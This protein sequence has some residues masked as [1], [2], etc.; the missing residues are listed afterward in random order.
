MSE[1]KQD[2][3]SRGCY[4][5][6]GADRLGVPEAINRAYERSGEERRRGETEKDQKGKIREPLTVVRDRSVWRAGR[7]LGS[8]VIGPRSIKCY[9][10]RISWASLAD[11][12]IEKY[13]SKD[14]GANRVTTTK[15]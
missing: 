10:S 9:E 12:V 13:C 3:G 8:F 11:H 6:R 14:D 5:N 7:V 2:G 15:T 4:N 1:T